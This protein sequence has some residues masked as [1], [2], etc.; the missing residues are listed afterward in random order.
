MLSV[1]TIAGG[2]GLEEIAVE[3]GRLWQRCPRATPFQTPE[4]L[5]AW[6]RAFGRG[7]PWTLTFRNSDDRL[8]GVAPM[9]VTEA[10]GTWTLRLIGVGVSDYLD[11]LVQPGWEDAV[12]GALLDELDRHSSRWDVAEFQHLTP[13]SPLVRDCA[14]ERLD[15]R[16]GEPCPVVSLRDP[17]ISSARLRANIA[18]DR[19]RLER[20]MGPVSFEAA[21]PE[22]LDWFLDELRRLHAARWAARGGGVL[23]S[24]EVGAFHAEAARGLLARGIARLCALRV[25]ARTAGVYYGFVHAGRAYYYIGGFDPELG[26]FG[27]GNQLVAH[28]IDEARRE[29]AVE[30][31]FLRGQEAYKYRWG[32][33][34]RPTLTAR[35]VRRPQSRV[36]V[37]SRTRARHTGPSL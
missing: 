37:P 26:A 28:A 15:T 7:R 6:W 19:R 31:D 24:A 35:M 17:E 1:E 33:R 25:D 23:A 14:L 13:A 12:A 4:W 2:A 3:W 21:T 9:Y 11:V 8:V 20:R 5:L 10:G 29:G 30:F 22:T 27:I 36:W 18:A 34:D 32:A 16:A